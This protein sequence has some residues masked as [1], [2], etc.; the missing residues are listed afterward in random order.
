MF[1]RFSHAL[2][3]FGWLSALGSTTAYH[4]IMQY[5]DH[6]CSHPGVTIPLEQVSAGELAG[7]QFTTITSVPAGWSSGD[8]GLNRHK[9]RYIKR[10]T[11]IYN[12][13]LKTAEGRCQV[14]PSSSSAFFLLHGD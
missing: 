10:Y 7:L 3:P 8:Q 4:A 9:Y 14:G 2:S 13:T 6:Y 11:Y 12:I 5:N 1:L